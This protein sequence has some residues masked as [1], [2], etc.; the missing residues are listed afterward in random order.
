MQDLNLPNMSGQNKRKI[1]NHPEFID[2]VRG[3]FP[4]GDELYNGAG[5]RDKNHIQLCIVNPNCI[6]GFF[7]PIQHNS[8][9]KSI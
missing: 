1:Q 5:F 6:I 4:E 7:D 8:W 3:M 2:S 9:Y